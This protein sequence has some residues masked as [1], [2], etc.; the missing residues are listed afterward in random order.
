MTGS[1][2]RSAATSLHFR[3]AELATIVS[4]AT[5]RA[6]AGR[7]PGRCEPVLVAECKTAGPGDALPDELVQRHGGG[8]H[9]GC[10]PSYGS[11]RPLTR[12]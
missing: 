5:P 11:G 12:R 2:W 9:H 4:L 6:A 7:V 1:G 3:A 10:C 8:C